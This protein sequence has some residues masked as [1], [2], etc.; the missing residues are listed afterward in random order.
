[1]EIKN[2]INFCKQH[3]SLITALA[4]SAGVIATGVTAAI[5]TVKA[6][7]VLAEREDRETMTTTDK[8]KTCAKSYIP[9]AAVGALTIGGVFLLKKVTPIEIA[10]VGGGVM[11]YK[12][13]YEKYSG[14]VKNR[15]GEPVHNAIIDEI[16]H[17]DQTDI[18]AECLCEIVTADFEDDTDPLC[19][20]YDTYSKRYFASTKQK[21]L[22]AEYHL[23]RN[24]A[25]GMCPSVNDF[26]E[27]LGIEKVAGGDCDMLDIPYEDGLQ[28]IDFRHERKTFRDGSPYYEI[29]TMIDPIPANGEDWM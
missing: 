15:F 21:V 29:S 5:D 10:A 18:Q 12:K 2:V 24:F 26:Y 6:Q 11:S 22:Q 13:L 27:L 28:W 3:A 20:F 4:T 7:K 14:V 25:L 23:N 9:S 16:E 8:V 1:M 19:V 17:A